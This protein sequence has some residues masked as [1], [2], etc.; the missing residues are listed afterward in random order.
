LMNA[1]RWTKD[2]FIDDGSI[3]SLSMLKSARKKRRIG[4]RLA[5]AASF[6]CDGKIY[7][8]RPYWDRPA[9]GYRENQSHG[10]QT[11]SVVPRAIA[12]GWRT[13]CVVVLDHRS[14]LAG[15][16]SCETRDWADLPCLMTRLII[17][18]YSWLEE[19]DWKDLHA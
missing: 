11:L 5:R 17:R 19:G 6:E 7:G 2:V 8:T 13:L 1:R 14:A 9:D 3:F 10:F 12:M 4:V 15:A 16:G 18:A